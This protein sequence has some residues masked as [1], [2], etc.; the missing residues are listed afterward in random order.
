MNLKSLAKIATKLDCYGGETASWV[1]TAIDFSL[2]EARGSSAPYDAALHCI[3]KLATILEFDGHTDVSDALNIVVKTAAEH[4]QKQDKLYDSKENNKQTYWS[5]LTSEVESETEH[6][7]DSMRGGAHP[8][9]TRYSPDYPGVML[10]RISDGVYQDLLSK[11]VYDFTSGFVSDTGIRYY[12][13]S[14][15]LQTPSAQN[16]SNSPAIWESQNLQS[17]PR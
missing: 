13:G 12:G 5:A 15:A 17:R 4:K 3:S 6:H 1:A 2:E 16:A 11:K 9:L 8:L 14:V 10:M 7:L